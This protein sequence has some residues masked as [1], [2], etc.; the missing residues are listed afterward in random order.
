MSTSATSFASVAST[1]AAPTIASTSDGYDASIHSPENLERMVRLTLWRDRVSQYQ[2]GSLPATP[3]IYCLSNST[4]DQLASGALSGQLA[5]IQL[6][7]GPASTSAS[8]PTLASTFTS[9]QS[10]TPT[11]GPASNQLG[12]GETPAD[13]I[14]GPLVLFNTP[15]DHLSKVLRSS[16]LKALYEGFIGWS[17]VTYPTLPYNID[18]TLN[19]GI[20]TY[21][22]RPATATRLWNSAVAVA[23]IIKAS[24]NSH[25]PFRSESP[26][27]NTP[28]PDYV[29]E[30]IRSE[31]LT[32]ID[33][34]LSARSNPL[35]KSCSLLGML[36]HEVDIVV[37]F[38]KSHMAWIRVAMQNTMSQG[39]N[40]LWNFGAYFGISFGQFM[41]LV[42]GIH[43]VHSIP[44]SIKPSA[45][46]NN[47]TEAEIGMFGLINRPLI[48]DGSSKISKRTRKRTHC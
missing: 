17:S 22:L 32:E 43:D 29:Y 3:H 35:S 34:V 23:T 24:G 12:M 8:G 4:V 13:L 30:S 21:K 47:I 20:L 41:E 40:S 48:A 7:P 19:H 46:L 18:S 16:F 45:D 25:N 39:G 36:Y 31:P 1:I 15:G 27:L 42:S 5:H 14:P 37:K 28:I 2:F 33:R 9:V 10:T 6:A 44:F 38:V 11:P 26:A